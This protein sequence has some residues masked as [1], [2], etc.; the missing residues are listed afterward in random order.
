M[1]D[2]FIALISAAMDI[3]TIKGAHLY[4]PDFITIDGVA[5]DGKPFDISFNFAN[6]GSA[7]DENKDT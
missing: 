4:S 7:S 3:G 1:V 6:D 2:I 5:T